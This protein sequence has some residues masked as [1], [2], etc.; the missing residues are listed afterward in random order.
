MNKEYFAQGIGN[1][2]NGFFGGMGGDAMVG[3]SIINI[4]SGA[5]ARWSGIIA[6]IALIVFLLFL[7]PF[8][9]AIPLAS[10]V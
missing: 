9:N 2:F 4:K 5:R 10:L 6:A 1:L 8:V 7:S 3:Q